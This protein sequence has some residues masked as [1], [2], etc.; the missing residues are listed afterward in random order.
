MIRRSDGSILE[1][2]VL[3]YLIAKGLSQGHHPAGIARR[4]GIVLARAVTVNDVAYVIEHKLR[5]MGVVTAPGAIGAAPAPARQPSPLI[6][7][8]RIL[9]K[10][11][12][13]A[14]TLLLWPLFL[15]LVMGVVLL[16]LVAT[17]GWLL[18]RHGA[19]P[20]I[21]FSDLMV[22][23]STLGAVL[24]FT[25]VAALF[26]ELGHATASRYGGAEPG[27]I[28]VGLYLLWPV[29]YNDLNDCYRLSRRARLRADLGGVYFNA[30]F[31]LALAG[32]Y[33]VT[34]F[35]AIYPAIV[36]QHIAVAQQFLPFLRLD[37]YY[38]VSDLAGVPD[39]FGRIRPTL[40]TLL[41]PGWTADA[42]TD[43]TPR[44]RAIVAVWVVTTVPVLTGLTALLVIGLPTFVAGAWTSLGIQ[45][46]RL[47]TA[48]GDSAPGELFAAALQLALL[49]VPLI[50]LG[51]VVVRMMG[52]VTA[53]LRPTCAGGSR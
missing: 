41:R 8:A 4:A 12:V 27:I 30:V 14:A 46:D 22:R 10:R 5:P 6:L 24:G 40:S 25:L 42:M 44:A 35:E 18:L 32:L 21:G 29:F 2:S 52:A 31:I 26:H 23:P 7:R 37:G 3:L 47:A 16:A 50:G 17:D 20:G 43:L 49:V 13:G 36:V 33:A 45:T 51:A 1:V 48:V 38:V 15:P 11:L 34:G 39:L 19:G 28:G 53:R 9:P